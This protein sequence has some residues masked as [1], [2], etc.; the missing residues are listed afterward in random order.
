LQSALNEHFA[1][2]AVWKVGKVALFTAEKPSA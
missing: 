1:K 2:V